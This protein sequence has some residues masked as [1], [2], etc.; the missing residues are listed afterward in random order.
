MPNHDD[1]TPL[2][3]PQPASAPAEV[4]LTD[5][6]RPLDA[7]TFDLDAFL[8]GVRPTRRTVKIHERADLVGA[9]DYIVAQIDAAPEGEDVDHLI[10]QYTEARD[11][12]LAG[13][14]YWTVE[15]RSSEWLK[16]HREATARELSITINK[17]G[18]AANAKGG[19]TLLLEQV[20][21]QVVEINSQPAE[22]T[23]EQLRKMY[24]ANE[25]EVNKLVAAVENVNTAMAQH[26]A[27]DLVTRDFSRRFSTG[28]N[29]AAS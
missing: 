7:A 9:M 12:F 8:N 10:E 22:V 2:S 4:R 25:G 5:S 27:K 14:T 11:T 26:S 15:K 21:A 16:A 6:T 20:A 24:D 18:E 3:A 17:D 28:R 1:D 19:L 29:G 13:V 23:A